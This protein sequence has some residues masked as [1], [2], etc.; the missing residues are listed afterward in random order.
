M[1]E[2]IIVQ[3]ENLFCSDYNQFIIHPLIHRAL[4]LST[5]YC[6]TDSKLMSQYMVKDHMMAHYKKIV[7]AKCK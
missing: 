6:V 1:S 5:A 3:I 7:K 4:I 2:D